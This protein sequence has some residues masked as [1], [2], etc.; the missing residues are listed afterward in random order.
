MASTSAYGGENQISW[1]VGGMDNPFT[2]AYYMLIG[3]ATSPVAFGSWA[4]PSGVLDSV[5]PGS[6]GYSVSST[7]YAEAGTYSVY[8]FARTPAEGKYYP[9]G[10]AVV[11]VTEAPKGPTA[12]VWLGSSWAK[13]IPYVYNG[14]AWVPAN[15]KIYDGGWK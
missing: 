6:G 1:T 11:T 13:A 12:Y 2:S 10:S 14:S 3:I 4:P 15:A 8:G 9:A 7:C 5:Y